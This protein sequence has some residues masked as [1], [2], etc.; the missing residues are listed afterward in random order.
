MQSNTADPAA[1]F[2]VQAMFPFLT[3]KEAW[4]ALRMMI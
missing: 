2:P 3:V 1:R 4:Q